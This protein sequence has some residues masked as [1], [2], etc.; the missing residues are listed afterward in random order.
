MVTLSLVMIVKN[1]SAKLRRCLDSV[2]LLVDEIIIVDTGSEDNTK[3][4]AMKYEAKVFDYAWNHNFAEA[5]NFALEQSTG[6]WNLILDGDEYIQKESWEEIKTFIKGPPKIGRIKQINIFEQDGEL[7]ESQA[8][9]SRLIPKNV[10]YVGSIHEQVES[11]SL[12]RVNTN[13][14]VY[15]DGYFQTN[16]TER[17]VN[18][19]KTALKSNTNDAY[20]LYQLANEHRINRNYKDAQA[21]F[22]RS[23]ALVNPEDGFKP[24]LVVS[25]LYNI[26]ALKDNIESGLIIIKNEQHQFPDFPDFYF[27]CGFYY[28]ELVFSN[29]QK[30]SSY[31]SYIEKFYLKCLEIGETNKYDSVKGTGSFRAAYNLG[32]YYETTGNLKYAIDYYR[33]SAESGYDIALQ[34]IINLD[35]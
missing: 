4:I 8:L 18:L 20:L 29:I 33:Q 32:V 14:N 23:Y 17:N 1:E 22:E 5:R 24:A 6:E 26:I 35:K 9:I 28:M 13:I 34:R 27:V 30:Y 2:K 7:K 19:L 16:K 15:H 3:E 12:Q 21:Y 11:Q 10:R 31:F 25:Y